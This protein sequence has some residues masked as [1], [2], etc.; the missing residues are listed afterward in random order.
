MY[1]LDSSALIESINKTESHD[2]IIKIV[3]DQP[4]ITTS[5]CMQETL[6]GALS[7]RDKFVLE[8][9]FTGIRVL[10]HNAEAAKIGAEITQKLAKKGTMIGKMDILIAAICKAH[11]GELIT[12]DKDFAKIKVEG[13]K[14]HI[15]S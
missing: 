14:S 5:I 15:I 1:V 4:V 7:E 9:I 6:V 8:N 12:L 3:K 10:E 11:Q 13:F 2:K